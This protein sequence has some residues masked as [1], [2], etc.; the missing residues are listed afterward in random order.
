MKESFIRSAPQKD[1][2]APT[3]MLRDAPTERR[4]RAG[5]GGGAHIGRRIADGT[6][7][8]RGIAILTVPA[9]AIGDRIGGGFG[10]RIGNGSRATSANPILRS[11]RANGPADARIPPTRFGDDKSNAAPRGTASTKGKATAIATSCSC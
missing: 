1:I 2:E 5:E 3:P 8:A 10:E 6:R 7:A 11:R 9:I 4:R